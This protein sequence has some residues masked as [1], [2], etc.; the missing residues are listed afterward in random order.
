MNEV[1]VNVAPVLPPPF[2][3]LLFPVPEKHKYNR[4]KTH[5]NPKQPG[6]EFNYR[7]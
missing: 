7:L 6:E 4:L 2:L 5:K 3:L 1:F